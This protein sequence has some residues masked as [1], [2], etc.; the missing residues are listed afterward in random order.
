MKIDVVGHLDDKHLDEAWQLYEAAFTDLDA[1]TVQRHLMYRNEFDEVAADGRVDKYLALDDD[2]SLRGLA[3]FTNM[4]AAMPLISPRYFARRW[5]A[6]YAHDA[7]WYCGFVAVPEHQPGVF[8]ELVEAMYR[9]AE[10]DGGVIA[11]DV[12]GHNM[13][14]HRLDRGIAT[15]LR[16]VSAGRVR[17][18]LADTQ[19]FFVYETAPGVTV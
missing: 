9:R 3:T 14:V 18:G 8:V 16:R 10:E 19:N 6:L 2:G 7:I 4:L 5:P 13:A 17:C 1:L 15:L 11:L 12:C